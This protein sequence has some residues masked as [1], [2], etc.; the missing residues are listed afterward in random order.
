[1]T[2]GADTTS[3]GH[4][5]E[6]FALAESLE[7]APRE[8]QREAI[9]KL[10]QDNTL[11]AHRV[12]LMLGGDTTNASVDA[13]VTKVLG[14]AR[15]KGESPFKADDNIGAYT[16]MRPLGKGGMADV[17]LAQRTDGT[18]KR[19]VAL[20]LPMA[21]MPSPML[22]ER[23]ARERDML[24]QLDH[25]NI[26]RIY[27]AG[28]TAAGQPF[29]ALEFIDGEGLDHFCKAKR[30]TINARVQLVMQVA[31]AVHHAHSRLVLHRDLKPSNILVTREGIVK[32]LDFGIAKLLTEERTAE[33]TQFTRMTGAAL[34]PKYA[35][36][37]QLL[38]ETVTTSTDVYAIAVLL[39]ELLAGCVPFADQ[40]KD[41]SA[42]MATLNHPCRLLSENAIS[43][44]QVDALNA[45]SERNVK[46]ALAGDLT[47][48]LDKALRRAPN[49]RYP[50][51]LAFA[52]DLQRYLT[53]RPVQARQGAALYRIRKFFV[54][55]RVPVAVA[56]MGTLAAAGLGL[57]AFTQS[58][59]AAQSQ[60]RAD[61]IDGLM[62]SLFQG[63]S[64]D[65][66]SSRTFTAKELLDRAQG[67]I[68]SSPNAQADSAMSGRI[69]ALYRDIGAYKEA[70]DVFIAERDAELAHGNRQAAARAQLNIVDA[71]TGLNQ[72]D[73]AH[74]EINKFHSIIGETI[75][76]PNAL[77]ARALNLSGQ[78]EY[79]KQNAKDAITHY[80]AAEAQW[81]VITP[82]NVE[83]LI[84]AV[85][86]QA[87]ALRMQ[88]KLAEARAKMEDVLSLDLKYPTR[89]E[90][91][92]LRSRAELGNILLIDGRYAAA[93]TALA[94]VCAAQMARLGAKH[95]DTR[96]Y[97]R[98]AAFSYSRTGN[99][100]A[101]EAIL[102]RLHSETSDN[103]EF[104]RAMIGQQRALISM[105]RADAVSAE[106]GVR[107]AL[108]LTEARANGKTT[109]ATL[110]LRRQLG[111][112]LLRQFR[113]GEA[114]AVLS[115]VERAL[116]ATRGTQHPDTAVTSLLIAVASIRSGDF[117]SATERLRSA[118]TVLAKSRGEHHHFTLAA[119]IYLQL[120]HPTSSPPSTLLNDLQRE[121]GWQAGVPE[122]ITMA[123][124]SEK[125]DWSNRKIP[126]IL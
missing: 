60:Q 108:Q 123:S 36:P 90:V 89:G 74:T 99:F 7:S 53:N 57:Q 121:M 111:E 71:L 63:M 80:G 48:I 95:P 31:Q 88:V 86:G 69:G 119:R 104:E 77:L 93:L 91:D 25:P 114:V 126:L 103:D 14:G 113:D 29:L 41:L 100:N 70:R 34:T 109:D 102:A 10:A 20:K 16:L 79:R 97:C 59:R 39:Y 46:R 122:I 42:R 72:I 30:A 106:P 81:R 107:H 26:A 110:R 124:K 58:Q 83:Q 9:A 125:I 117:L 37:E 51:A 92:K 105:F 3:T 21:L 52:D 96:A 24:A 19:P 112:V 68:R 87:T 40:A 54:R 6:A 116:L 18:L 44:P 50:S 47:A 115:E 73:D 76:P 5:R 84:W 55:H 67:F 33:E 75:K 64:P 56:A 15:V 85:E 17:W 38:S 61:S 78:V 2:V 101:A 43:A 28:T 22:A 4:W 118:V 13:A 82:V 1:M 32:V 8:A 62:E 23:F 49:D 45:N 11:L 65:V 94:D 120:L 98:S 35:A 27:D 66:A 12:S